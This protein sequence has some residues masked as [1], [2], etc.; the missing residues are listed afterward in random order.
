MLISESVKM[1]ARHC[2]ANGLKKRTVE[3]YMRITE[4]WL[5]YTQ[6][7]N[8]ERIEDV[9]GDLLQDYFIFL[10][11]K[12]YSPYTLRGNWITLNVFFNFLTE[13]GILLG[14]PLKRAVKKPVLPKEKARTFKTAEILSI[15][16]HYDKTDFCG[17]RNFTIMAVFYGTGIRRSELLNLMVYDIDMD[18]RLLVVT[19]KGDKMREI[20]ISPRLARILKQYIAMR[21]TL[22]VKRKS[23]CSYLFVSNHGNRLS[24]DGLKQVFRNLKDDLNIE[25]RR[26][27]PHTWRHSFARNFLVNGGNVFTLQKILGHSDIATTQVYITWT[28]DEVRPQVDKFSPLEN[29]NWSYF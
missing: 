18:A 25:G 5:A 12:K 15:L 6:K 7:Q 27:S 13:H 10:R 2:I 8:I 4:T 14:N 22:L 1:F 9:K 28:E 20:P 17:M 3:E 23:D 11:G 19:G 21:Q 29:R 16:N 24:Q 26:V